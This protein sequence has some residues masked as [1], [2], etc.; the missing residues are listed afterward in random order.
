[1]VHL[2]KLLKLGGFSVNFKVLRQEVEHLGFARKEIPPD[3][4]HSDNKTRWSVNALGQA[5][6]DTGTPVEITRALYIDAAEK[7]FEIPEF[8]TVRER[9]Q[10][11]DERCDHVRV[12]CA[13]AEKGDE[14][15]GEYLLTALTKD[16]ATEVRETVLSKLMFA[17]RGPRTPYHR[18]LVEGSA[19]ALSDDV[20]N[21]RGLATVLQERAVRDQDNAEVQIQI[22]PQKRKDVMTSR[23][24]C[25][26]PGQAQ[27]A[28]TYS[29]GKSL[30]G[31]AWQ[32]VRDLAMAV[33]DRDLIHGVVNMMLHPV[34]PVRIAAWETFGAK[35]TTSTKGRCREVEA[36]A[37]Q[38]RV[39]FE[40][41]EMQMALN[42]HEADACLANI[43][44]ENREKITRVI[45]KENARAELT[46][47]EVEKIVDDFRNELADTDPEYKRLRNNVRR[48]D[49]AMA[50]LSDDLEKDLTRYETIQRDLNNEIMGMI[51]SLLEE[52]CAVLESVNKLCGGNGKGNWYVRRCLVRILE[53][54][55]VAGGQQA[56]KLLEKCKND[57]S[58]YV[59]RTVYR[60]LREVSLAERQRTALAKLSSDEVEASRPTSAKNQT[61]EEKAEQDIQDALKGLGSTDDGDQEQHSNEPSLEEKRMALKALRKRQE[62]A[63][64]EARI[65]AL[66]VSEFTWQQMVDIIESLRPKFNDRTDIYK[67]QIRMRKLDGDKI[68]EM[69]KQEDSLVQGIK[70]T[71]RKHRV[72]LKLHIKHMME[73]WHEA[74]D[75]DKSEKRFQTAL[76]SAARENANDLNALA[77]ERMS[78][79]AT[80][81]SAYRFDNY[82]YGNATGLGS[83]LHRD[84]RGHIIFRRVIPCGGLVNDN[85]TL[86]KIGSTPVE[87]L[88][89]VEV[90]KLF[91]SAGELAPCLV[92]LTSEKERMKAIE[93][94]V[95]EL[96]NEAQAGA[97]QRK[98][99]VVKKKKK[100][101]AQDAQSQAQTDLLRT[102]HITCQPP[103]F[104]DE[105]LE[106]IGLDVEIYQGDATRSLQVMT[107]LQRNG[108][109]KLLSKC[110][111]DLHVKK[112]VQLAERYNDDAWINSVGIKNKAERLKFKKM[113]ERLAFR[114][115]IRD[116]VPEINH[117]DTRP[118]AHKSWVFITGQVNATQQQHCSHY[119][120]S[121]VSQNM[122]EFRQLGRTPII[123]TTASGG[124]EYTMCWNPD[125]KIAVELTHASSG[126][127]RFAMSSKR[128]D[129]T[130]NGPSWAN[131]VEQ[132]NDGPL[133][134][135]STF[136]YFVVFSDGH[137]ESC[138]RLN[139]IRLLEELLSQP[140]VEDFH[141]DFT[142]ITEGVNGLQ[143]SR[144]STQQSQLPSISSAL[145]KESINHK[146]STQPPEGNTSILTSGSHLGS[147]TKWKNGISRFFATS[148]P[149]S[150]SSDP[151][152]MSQRDFGTP[153]DCPPDDCGTSGMIV[154]RVPEVPEKRDRAWYVK[155]AGRGPSRGYSQHRT[156]VKEGNKWLEASSFQSTHSCVSTALE[157]TRPGV[158]SIIAS[159]GN[160]GFFGGKRKPS[161]EEDDSDAESD[162]D[163][164]EDEEVVGF[165][166]APL[167]GHRVI[168]REK[169]RKKFPELVKETEKSTGSITWVDPT[170]A[171]GDGAPPSPFSHFCILDRSTAK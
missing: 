83:M 138:D 76:H 102:V 146:A 169:V 150:G 84:D 113:L 166:V 36:L 34:L 33:Q 88:T 48:F 117:E 100:I 167:V 137:I 97:G 171:D 5:V 40:G 68:Y 72:V 49:K 132:A 60:S 4:P 86:I 27:D 70:M 44:E 155:G 158:D 3:T 35:D 50:E 21:L 23:G 31:G 164:D 149:Q 29:R 8:A 116:H 10:L 121:D 77:K 15:S 28:G 47:S 108:F 127:F 20:A 62:A 25:T 139:A 135:F 90:K 168:L 54:M 1:M 39:K 101:S 11:V 42:R 157:K 91:Q 38:K 45:E 112:L 32:Q 110:L 170:D 58:P 71:V 165:H 14:P 96:A 9:Q 125:L 26:A 163:S 128:K 2:A 115:G 17:A 85:D 144:P 37:Y 160:M 66:N 106:S 154:R 65:K 78:D 141:N 99:S 74:V 57:R 161:V 56:I 109:S 123:L 148:C 46:A 131:S 130:A 95:A 145:Q 118:D 98:G 151:A 19:V 107:F 93:E 143:K 24:E 22:K 104:R 111:V 103:P 13:L 53:P 133:V 89:L 80:I 94:N 147:P 79:G 82:A 124:M 152:S 114:Y 120:T 16:P 153:D 126:T 92:R 122:A 69:T 43:M 136:D 156:F 159:G 105:Y 140:A 18:K 81:K 134:D 63:E 30:G 129:S 119:R 73:A 12:L 41:M 87:G 162:I 75:A 51:G 7:T 59:R 64:E 67:K 142:N 61:E 55:A 6:V 52:K